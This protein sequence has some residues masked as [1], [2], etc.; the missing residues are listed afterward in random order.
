MLWA[1]KT[2]IKETMLVLSTGEKPICRENS[3]ATTF[4]FQPRDFPF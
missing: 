4:F 2:N 1:V 3:P